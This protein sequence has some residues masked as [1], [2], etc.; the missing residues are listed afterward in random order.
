MQY[1][2]LGY[3]PQTQ[4]QL[5]VQETIFEQYEYYGI[6]Y[7]IFDGSDETDADIIEM[8]REEAKLLIMRGEEIPPDLAA[9]LL[10]YKYQ[11]RN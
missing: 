10:E 6:P 7:G 5:K 4:E 11:D 2:P 9:K 8:D 3:K 1:L